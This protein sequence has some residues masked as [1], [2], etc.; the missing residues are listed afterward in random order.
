MRKILQILILA[1]IMTTTT[2]TANET[3]TP[4]PEPE[5]KEVKIIEKI[6]KIWLGNADGTILRDSKGQEYRLTFIGLFEE[7]IVEEAEAEAEAEEA[8]EE[9]AEENE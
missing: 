6:V 3:P 8:E 2:A 7:E 1:M 4:T 5:K 9:I